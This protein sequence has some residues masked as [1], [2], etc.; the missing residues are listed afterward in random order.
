MRIPRGALCAPT[1]NRAMLRQP[2]AAFD[3]FKRPAHAGGDRILHSVDDLCTTM[4]ES[5]HLSAHAMASVIL[6]L[7]R[8]DV[9]HNTAR[10]LH[11][12]N[13]DAASMPDPTCLPAREMIGQRAAALEHLHRTTSSVSFARMRSRLMQAIAPAAAALGCAST[14]ASSPRSRHGATALNA[15]AGRPAQAEECGTQVR[16]GARNTH[17]HTHCLLYQRSAHEKV[18]PPCRCLHAIRVSRAGDVVLGDL[19][20]LKRPSQPRAQ[21]ASP[22]DNGHTHKRTPFRATATACARP[23]GA[24]QV[25]LSSRSAAR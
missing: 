19:P 10:M 3:S 20:A 2:S 12:P 18:Q 15:H 13:T 5:G 22:L 21:A 25:R 8:S 6:S 1:D 11:Q 17:T 16:V 23:R 14:D 7:H 24:G 9:I 4:R